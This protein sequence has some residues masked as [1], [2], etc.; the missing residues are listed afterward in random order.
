MNMEDSFLMKYFW[1]PTSW[2]PFSQDESNAEVTR[3]IGQIYDVA[4]KICPVTA[5][6]NGCPSPAFISVDA[7]N[8]Q[9]LYIDH[10]N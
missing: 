1:F 3:Y 7:G 5:S 4:V 9:T 8:Q 6:G 10:L 2:F